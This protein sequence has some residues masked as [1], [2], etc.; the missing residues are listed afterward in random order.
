MEGSRLTKWIT[1]SENYRTCRPVAVGEGPVLGNKALLRRYTW[2]K[3]QPCQIVPRALSGCQV[4]SIAT[5]FD[6]WKNVS[7]P[8]G[9]GVKNQS[10]IPLSNPPSITTRWDN[11][12]CLMHMLRDDP[13]FCILLRKIY[14]CITQNL[15]DECPACFWNNPSWLASLA[16]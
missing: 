6:Y 7:F 11:S 5:L 10:E 9:F 12:I 4:S 16:I 2:E 8:V 14:P 15:S 1:A 13:V 3:S